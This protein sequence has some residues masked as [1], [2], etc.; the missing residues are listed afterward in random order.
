MSYKSNPKPRNHPWR[1]LNTPR[2]KELK[3]LNAARLARQ[4]YAE[5]RKDPILRDAMI[6]RKVA[7]AKQRYQID[8]AFR[9]KRKAYSRQQRQKRKA[10]RDV[11]SGLKEAA[12]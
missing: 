9:D 3:R 4:R 10:A 2:L 12:Q 6:K 1:T 7:R 8:P 5:D 11:I